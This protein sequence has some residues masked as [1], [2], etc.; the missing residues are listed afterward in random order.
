MA[1]VTLVE[2]AERVGLTPLEIAIK[3]AL[4]GFPCE[5]G[6][7]DDGVLP[8]I[9]A[10]IADARTDEPG[11]PADEGAG[12]ETEQERRLR[13]VRRVLERLANTGKWMPARIERRAAARGLGGPEVGLALH[14]VDVMVDCG[15]MR[16]EQH[17]G[18]E[19]RVG[20]NGE[21]RR[22]VVEIVEGGRVADEAL[23]AWVAGS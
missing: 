22:E 19:Q 20:L 6:V 18:K 1:T 13:I 15:L 14:A 3:C 21:R 16:A 23:R 7:L 10:V 9:G 12:A 11:S 4:R 8:I 2:A 17:G 5:G